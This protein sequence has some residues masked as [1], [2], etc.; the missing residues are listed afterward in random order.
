LLAAVLFEVVAVAV[1]LQGM[2]VV[3]KPVQQG[4]GDEAYP[5]E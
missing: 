5:S 1:H 4:G 2:D 3:G